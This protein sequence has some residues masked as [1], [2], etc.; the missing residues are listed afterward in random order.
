MDL[1]EKASRANIGF[2]SEQGILNICQVW[3]LPLTSSNPRVS[4]L[5]KTARA[6]NAQLKQ[7]AEE[8]FVPSSVTP[9]KK[10]RELQLALDVVKHIIAV[11]L[12]EENRQKLRAEGAVI[13]QKI[14]E[15]I[16]S[17]QED[18]LKN[19]SLEEL[20]AKLKEVDAK[21]DSMN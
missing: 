20:Q 6:I 7:Y 13:R 11:K 12:A 18:S 10:Q 8:S 3:E 17:K 4:T 1:F 14:V 21:L 5:D 16:A 2:P 19:S 15:A 9:N